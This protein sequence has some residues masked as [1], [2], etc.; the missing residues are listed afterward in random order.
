LESTTDT[1][2]SFIGEE[3]GYFQLSELTMMIFDLFMA[4]SD[5]TSKSLEWVC[6]FMVLYPEVS[7][8]SI[9]DLTKCFICGIVLFS[10]MLIE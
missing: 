8:V 2:I 4:A 6:L 3:V 7:G 10:E 9:V 5:T 1:K